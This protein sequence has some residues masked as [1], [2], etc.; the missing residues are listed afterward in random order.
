MKLLQR[1]SFTL[2]LMSLMTLVAC[3]GGEG[4]L[5]GDDGGGTVDDPIVISLA[6]SNQNVTGLEPIIVAATLTKDNAVVPN[7]TVTFSSS[8]GAF[9]PSSGTTLTNDEGVAEITLTAGNVRG[10]GTITATVT[11]GEESTID[12]STQGDDIGVVV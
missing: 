1:F 4:D 7:T 3:G 5:T 2:L 10:A 9:S 8:I 12:F 6:L 11:S